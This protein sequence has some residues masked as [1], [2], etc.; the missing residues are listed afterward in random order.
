MLLS[1]QT[2]HALGLSLWTGVA[3]TVLAI[4]LAALLLG[5]AWGRPGWQR[6]V[7]GLPPMLA[8]PHAAFAIGMVMLL[9]PSGWLARLL[10][11]WAT[12]WDAPPLWALTQDPWGLGLILVLVLK[13]VPFLLWVGAAQLQHPQVAGRLQQDLQV[14]VSMGYTP[15]GAWWRLG[16]PRLA[17]R[18]T[19]PM[20]AVLA[21][22]IGNVDMAWIA[23]PL[24]PPTLAV[25]CWE[26]LQDADPA[27]NALGARM[28]W[29]LVAA[30]LLC[31]AVAA[32]LR[33][34]WH[35]WRLRGVAPAAGTA[36][37]SAPLLNVAGR[38]A[39]RRVAMLRPDTLLSAV[40][41]AV[42]LA[43]LLASLLGPWPFPDLL[44]SRWTVQ[45]WHT[46]LDSA[47]TLR[48]TL[49]LGLASAL[50][51]L[52]ASVAWL[53]WVGPRNTRWQR[54]G[55]RLLM[56]PLLLPPVLWVVWLHRL[57]LAWDLD[58]QG[59][60]VWLAHTVAVLPYVWLA[61]EG[62]YRA[63]DPR[64]LQ[65]AHSL[66]HGRWTVR[67]RIQWP[68][69]RGAL[70]ASFAVG[71]AVSVAQY[72][73]TL[74]VGAGRF[75]TVTTEAMALASGGHATLAA[76]YAWLQWLLPVLVFGLAAWLGRAR[77]FGPAPYRAMPDMQK[78]QRDGRPPP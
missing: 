48:T 30:L 53:E 54:S 36:V 43:L 38:R 19:T 4:G 39:Q 13:E 45:S 49:W 21:Y 18:M 59:V 70:A 55:E 27:L 7:A 34:V 9:A 78:W 75:N 31:V 20:L 1:S 12:G 2:L 62:P 63:F 69:L 33:P 57:M 14:A 46:V 67:W 29:L 3:S 5:H 11:P 60:G 42:M 52:V 37:A 35:R 17:R 32:A 8:T 16:W 61:L 51:S 44:P 41:L 66:G 50:A 24:T 68:L 64:I 15:Q 76:A 6:M 77:R 74:Y 56:L 71:F 22:G 28:S 73:P 40:Y 26:W 72:L 10:S 47:N 25:L 58:T 65:V 23:G